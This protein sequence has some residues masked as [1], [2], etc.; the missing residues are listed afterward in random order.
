MSLRKCLAGLGLLLVLLCLGAVTYLSVTD[1]GKFK[2]EIEKAVGDATG[3]AFRIDGDLHIDVFPSP[4][5]SVEQASLANARW[6]T[7]PDMLDVGHFSARIGLWSLLFPPVV[8]R[9]TRLRD[10]TLLL[11][12]N[13]QG[14]GNWILGGAEPD[15]GE[16]D[17]D[18]FRLP[19][20]IRFAEVSDVAEDSA[21]WL[22]VTSTVD[23][24]L[25]ADCPHLKDCFVMKARREAQEADMV[26]VNHHLFFADMAVKQEGFAEVLPGADA[27]ILDE[28]HQLPDVAGHF[29]GMGGRSQRHR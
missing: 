17:G 4:A 26:V 8:I 28:A 21:L 10:V 6:G 16:S 24:C 22:R 25:G 18:P 14:Q 13:E 1:L 19:V 3:R 29:F 7:A 23:N 15:A 12:V 27:F 5:F 9:D 20:D 11:E 2:T